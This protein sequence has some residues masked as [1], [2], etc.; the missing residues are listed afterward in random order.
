MLASKFEYRRSGR[1]LGKKTSGKLIIDDGSNEY[2]GEY[3]FTYDENVIDDK[4][5]QEESLQ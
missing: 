2:E 3:D 5:D 1:C 4:S